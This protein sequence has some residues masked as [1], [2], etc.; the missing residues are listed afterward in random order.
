[1]QLSGARIRHLIGIGM[2]VQPDISV[3]IPDESGAA[4]RGC[5]NDTERVV[6]YREQGGI[7]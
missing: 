3:P 1:M 5:Q 2:N 6:P 7:E 4:V